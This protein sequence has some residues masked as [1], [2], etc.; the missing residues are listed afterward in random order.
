MVAD[1]DTTEELEGET[2]ASVYGPGD[3]PPWG[4]VVADADERTSATIGSSSSTS[5]TRANNATL[6]A[7]TEGG[8]GAH[9]TTGNA[10]A[11]NGSTSFGTQLSSSTQ[12]RH[13]SFSD[14]I[15]PPGRGR[16]I[17]PLSK[18][19]VVGNTTKKQ[20]ANESASKTT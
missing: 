19:G 5:E 6:P 13:V 17:E 2:D 4:T 11:G 9:C 14:P 1:D 20:K 18:D 8:G 10:S 7:T 16:E 15:S 12:S 3:P